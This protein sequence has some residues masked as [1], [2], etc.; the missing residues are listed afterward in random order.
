MSK[1]DDE[2]MDKERTI[3][4]G[5]PLGTSAAGAAIPRGVEMLLKLA[6]IDPTFCE[7]LVHMR[8]QAAKDLGYELTFSEAMVLEA[9]PEKQLRNMIAAMPVS[10]EERGVLNS[11]N[12]LRRVAD[13]SPLL[14]TMGIRPELYD[15]A[16]SPLQSQD[17]QPDPPI[18]E[19]WPNIDEL[20]KKAAFDPDFCR[21]LLSHPPKSVF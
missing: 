20:I 9:V 18:Q 12:P 1:S 3:V 21:L 14:A 13:D 11:V 16:G 19:D 5:R 6:A 4:G 17:T 8:G 7:R 2:R 10:E 15:L